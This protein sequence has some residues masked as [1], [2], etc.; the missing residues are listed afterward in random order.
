MIYL[1]D[2]DLREIGI[3]WRRLVGWIE[4][5]VRI[6]DEG[7]CV[8]PLKPYLRF[9]DPVNRIIAM[10]AFVGGAVDMAG[11]KW[12]AGFPNNYRQGLPRAHNTIIL[13]DPATGVP[14]AFIH[15]GLLNG[16]RTA[17]VSGAMLNAY[18]AARPGTR[19]K[20]GIIGWGPIGRLHLEMCRA[21]CGDRLERI[22]LYDVKGVAAETIPEP[23]RAVTTI[24][25]DWR[26]AYRHSNVVATCTVSADTYIDEAPQP[27]SL[28]LHV[29]LRDYKPEAAAHM[30][31][32]VVDDWKEV[33][34][35]NT[36]IE[37]L[38]LQHGLRESDT[39]TIG[40]VVL[41]QAL[42][43]CDPADPVFFNPMGLAVFDIGLAAY[44]VREA[45]RLGKGVN[46]GSSGT[47]V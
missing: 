7:D 10:P 33:C 1:N 15:S 11:I 37:R 20:L 36:D 40:D 2:G 31:V 28:L 18:M 47:T 29:S 42:A 17:A 24:A 25:D 27:G 4:Q 32:I 30:R 9:R 6:K 5:I 34:R 14:L 45:L 43:A 3:D 8:H 13:N 26:S 46:L 44:Y 12:I 39:L 38:H 16:L 41:R 21:L 22:V 35:E 23:V 19:I